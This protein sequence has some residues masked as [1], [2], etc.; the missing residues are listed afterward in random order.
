[1]PP[2]LINAL[3]LLMLLLPLA[4]IQW[5]LAGRRS[6]SRIVAPKEHLRWRL[7]LYSNSADAEHRLA[8]GA[9]MP[10]PVKRVRSARGQLARSSPA[11][12]WSLPRVELE[13]AVDEPF[14]DDVLDGLFGGRQ[15]LR[16]VTGNEAILD[17]EDCRLRLR[18]LPMV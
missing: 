9:D 1:M 7:E 11:A 5:N 17:T 10:F 6:A 8:D 2:L 16:F 3:A 12:S 15:R 13:I 14:A 4:A 18:A